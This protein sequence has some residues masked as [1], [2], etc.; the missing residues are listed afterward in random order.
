MSKYIDKKTLVTNTRNINYETGEIVEE[1]EVTHIKVCT[2][3]N[4]VKLYIKTLLTFKDLSANL[5]PVLIEF[6]AYMSYA[7]IE[8]EHGGQLIYVNSDMK[9]SIAKKLDLKIDSINKGLYK[10]VNAGIFRRVGTG[11]YQVNASLFGK[12]EWKDVKGIRANFDFKTGEAV[13]EIETI[14]NELIKKL[15]KI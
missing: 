14:E 10:F 2:E 8:N 1:E 11:T 9:K 13:A 5:N 4:Y 12:G 7:D 6:L 15:S 3:P